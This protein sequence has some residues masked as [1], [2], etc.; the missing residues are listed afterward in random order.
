MREWIK[1]AG[2]RAGKGALALAAGL[3][4]YGLPAAPA[5]ATVTITPI[6]ILIDGR[7]RYE[8]VFLLN[9][10]DETNI[11]E[12]EW[13]HNLQTESGYKKQEESITDFDLS[14]HLVFTPRRV[15]IEPKGRQAVRLAL[16]LPEGPPPPGEYR[17]HLRF[18]RIA[19]DQPGYVDP[20]D[21]EEVEGRIQTGL[22]FNVGYSIPVVYRVG[23]YD[24]Q[25]SI[26]EISFE[27]D[28]NGELTAHVPI[29]RTG[30]H[31]IYGYLEIYFQPAGGGEERLIGE[32]SNAHVFAERDSYTHKVIMLEELGALGPGQIRV[33]L[34]SA[35]Q[36]E[37]KRVFDTRTFPVN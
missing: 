29:S 14:E 27:R 7:E 32:L 8:Q 26:G 4:L 1:Q 2:R 19:A 3:A 16:R 11:Y 22:V 5:H 20:A 24:A 9:T 6:Q 33:V 28:K 13:I 25:A 18:L 10:S 15:T 37:E 30:I 12:I 36:E 21:R 17:A 35:L 23:E 34:R 31:G